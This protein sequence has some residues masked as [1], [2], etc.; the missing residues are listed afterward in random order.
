MRSFFIACLVLLPSLSAGAAE[1]TKETCDADYAA[2]IEEAE[3]NRNKSLAELE[4]QL[5][6]A[7]DDDQAARLAAEMESTWDLEVTF[8]A[9]AAIAHRDCLKAVKANKS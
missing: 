8:R 1:L 4:Y 2:M 6:R 9:N 7:A 5:K 3:N